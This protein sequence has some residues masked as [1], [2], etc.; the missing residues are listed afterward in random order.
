[1]PEARKGRI[2]HK[3]FQIVLFAFAIVGCVA[4]ASRAQ[5]MLVLPEDS[6]RS[7]VMQRICITDVTISYHRPLVRNL[8]LPAPP[9][10]RRRR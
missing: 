5:T 3:N 6:Q 7:Q 10:V 8:T 1:M 4:T 9:Q 2:M